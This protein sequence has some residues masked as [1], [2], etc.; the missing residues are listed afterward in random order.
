MGEGEGEGVGM[1]TED[2]VWGGTVG[3]DGVQER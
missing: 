1:G 3:W 2:G